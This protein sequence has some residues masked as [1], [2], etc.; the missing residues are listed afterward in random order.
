MTLS[1]SMLMWTYLIFIESG[2]NQL[3]LPCGTCMPISAPLVFHQHH[4]ALWTVSKGTVTGFFRFY[5]FFLDFPIGHDC[6]DII[7]Q[8]MVCFRNNTLKPLTKK[9]QVLSTAAIK[10][11]SFYLGCAH[12]N[13][14]QLLLFTLNNYSTVAPAM[15]W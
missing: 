9:R 11:F 12:W 13:L 3:E 1:S 14:I 15:C 6:D 10:H 5:F 4:L 8:Y 7:C 2:I